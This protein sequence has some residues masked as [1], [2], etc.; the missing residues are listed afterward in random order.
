MAKGQSLRLTWLRSFHNVA[1][2]DK[3]DEC[4]DTNESRQS[5]N[6]LQSELSV[7][8]MYIPLSHDGKSRKTEMG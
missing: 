2:Q 7:E 1:L 4:K 5:E 6:C 8:R 3:I